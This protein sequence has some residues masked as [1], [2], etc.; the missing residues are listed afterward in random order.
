MEVT[1]S[2][3]LKIARSS[4]PEEL[5]QKGDLFSSMWREVFVTAEKMKA[6]DI[7]IIQEDDD[8]IVKLRILGDLFTIKE[9]PNEND[10]RTILINRLKAICRFDLSVTDEAQDR[11]FSLKIT[12]SRYR[13]V[14]TPGIFGEN[15]VFRVIRETDLPRISDCSIPDH[16]ST[17]LLFAINQRQ[18][19]ICITGPTGSGKSTT[20]QAAIMEIDRLKKNVI[21]IEDPVERIIPGVVQQQ[22]TSKLT[23]AKAIK[24]AMRQDPDVILVG[25]IRDVESAKL[26]LEAS[27]TG[28]LVLATLHTNNVAGIVDRLIGLGVEKRIIADNLLFIS[29]QRLVQRLCPDCRIKRLDFGFDRGKGCDKCSD[30]KIAGIKGRTSLIEYS[31]RPNSESIINFNKETFEHKELKTTLASEAKRLA[32]IGEISFDEFQYW[33]HDGI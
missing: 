5:I 20:L 3:L 28:H 33:S 27:Q 7:H 25:E 2:S 19:F 32:S 24:S 4:S 11:A 30:S 1:H 10:I 12:N 16:I 31:F 23:W 13:S 15:F 21:T 8:V 22:I 29:A 18:G 14:L 9:I 17:D 6:S 26:A